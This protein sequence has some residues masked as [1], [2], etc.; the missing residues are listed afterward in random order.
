MNY[1]LQEIKSKISKNFLLLT[2]G[3]SDKDKEE[4]KKNIDDILDTWTDNKTEFNK[5]VDTLKYSFSKSK[6]SAEDE[7]S[8]L[9]NRIL[10]ITL[11]S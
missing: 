2:S 10:L 8:V 11:I 5:I 7:L 1:T 4:V 3:L 9:S 6:L